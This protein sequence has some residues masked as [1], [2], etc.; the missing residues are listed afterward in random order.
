MAV[1]ETFDLDGP[2]GRLEAIL[3]TP[4]SAPLAAAVVCHAHPL[5]GGMMH[6]K[7]VFR[8]AKALQAAGCAVKRVSDKKL[9]GPDCGVRLLLPGGDYY[10]SQQC[11]ASSECTPYGGDLICPAFG[12]CVPTC[13]KD[14]T[15][16]ALGFKRCDVAG[17]NCDTI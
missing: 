11:T 13:T 10:C 5:H 2:A 16:V 12:A 8:V 15:C 14:D 4:V 6:F 3:T 7:V 1:K 9:C 17:G